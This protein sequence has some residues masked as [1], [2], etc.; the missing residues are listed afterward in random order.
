MSLRVWHVCGRLY[1]RLPSE[2]ENQPIQCFTED[3]I[4]V[5]WLLEE[6]KQHRVRLYK[7][8]GRLLDKALDHLE[9]RC[10]GKRVDNGAAGEAVQEDPPP[11][12]F[13]EFFTHF[14][15]PQRMQ[16]MFNPGKV[17]HA[18][19]HAWGW[20]TQTWIFTFYVVLFLFCV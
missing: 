15:Q 12:S 17:G 3:N 2:D 20:G 16:R 19:W 6:A 1:L 11:T 14:A 5:D 8:A 10:G 18:M 13:M 7:S 4:A 9:N